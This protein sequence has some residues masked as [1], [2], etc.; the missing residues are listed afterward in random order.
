M[1]VLVTGATGLIG[2]NV[3]RLLV[4]RGELVRA[5]VRPASDA[6]ALT[7]LGVGVASGDITSSDDVQRAAEG[8]TAIVNS[9]ALL[10]GAH[11]DLDEQL[12]ANHLGSRWCYDA[13]ARAGARVVELTTTPFLR[14]D[15]TLTEHPE[16]LPESRYAHDAY[17]VSKGRAFVDGR[18][19]AEAGEDICFVIPGGTFGPSPVVQRSMAAT[20]Y[21]RVLRGAIRGKV[22]A[23][24]TFPV[25][26][27]RAED[28]AAVVV[29]ALDSGDAGVAYLA[30]GKGP[31]T[32]TATFLNLGC[33]AAGVEH[34]VAEVVIS[35][36]DAERRVIYGETIFE[37]ATRVVPDPFYDDSETRRVLDPDPSSTAD[38]VAETVDWFRREGLL[39]G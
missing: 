16:V 17:A 34:R 36:D 24:P 32:S 3:C 1:T 6:T 13:A 27:V 12:A 26:W 23:Y 19:R 33:E 31:A 14:S 4:E 25:P 8:C 18:T 38:A 2:A 28:V 39:S 20:S 9:A 30:F 37:M 10:G 22:A 11:V 21:N 29:A 7:Q 15:V 35:R 5:L